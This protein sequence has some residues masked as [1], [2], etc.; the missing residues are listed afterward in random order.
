MPNYKG[1]LVGGTIAFLGTLHATTAL[2]NRPTVYELPLCFTVCLVASIFPD[3]DI[4]S[5]MQ[6][7][8]YISAALGIIAALLMHNLTLFFSIAATAILISQLQHRTI[9]HNVWFIITIPGFIVL[10]TS[11]Y[12]PVYFTT[13]LVYYLYFVA[14]AL[15][16]IL[17]DKTL[18]KIKKIFKRG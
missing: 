7:I 3:I 14:G 10:Y 11:F 4:T 2:F 1:H 13:S 12:K 9:T 6:R 18:T 16:H 5:K 17:L 8:F 15:S